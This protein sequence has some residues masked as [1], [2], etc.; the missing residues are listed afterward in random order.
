M[1]GQAAAVP[2]PKVGAFYVAVLPQFVPAGSSHLAM[3]F[4]L[5]GTYVVLG[6]FWSAV[7]VGLRPPA[8]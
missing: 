8:A 2:N 5:A 7:L 3:G 1:H 6:M 4:L